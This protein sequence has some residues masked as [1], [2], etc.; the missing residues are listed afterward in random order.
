M[1]LSPRGTR[2]SNPSKRSPLSA[3]ETQVR[4]IPR[5][6]SG[7]ATSRS[8]VRARSS[9]PSIRLL[10]QGVG[11]PGARPAGRP[12]GPVD[13]NPTATGAPARR[14]WGRR[15]INPAS[16]SYR[17]SSRSGTILGIGGPK[18]GVRSGWLATEL[19]VVELTVPSNARPRPPGRC[20]RPPSAAAPL[21][22]RPDPSWRPPPANP[23]PR[24]VLPHHHSPDAGFS[25]RG[26]GAWGKR[27]FAALSMTWVLGWAGALVVRG[28][29]DDPPRPSGR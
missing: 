14:G 1:K 4:V 23:S 16:P 13:Y 12:P 18:Q 15:P 6:R 26:V 25:I 11:R 2:G 8:A 21:A 9:A 27:C 3:H 7:L 28:E 17:G 5:L 29:A 24:Q 20:P 10:V 19:P 22:R